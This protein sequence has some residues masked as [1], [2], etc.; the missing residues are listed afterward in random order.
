MQQHPT[1]RSRCGPHSVLHL[2]IR[3][4]RR[5]SVFQVSEPISLPKIKHKIHPP[6]DCENP[7]QTRIRQ[8]ILV[9][10]D[11]GLMI[12][13]YTGAKAENDVL[14]CSP[15]FDAR[16]G[17]LAG[18]GNLPREYQITALVRLNPPPMYVV[19]RLPCFE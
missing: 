15:V 5:L 4:L 1:P 17:Q 10:N 18:F 12:P 2:E 9:Q 13:L 6:S 14:A 19:S 16:T 7:K 3:A 8:Q 11:N